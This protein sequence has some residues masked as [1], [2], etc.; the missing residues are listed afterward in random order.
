MKSQ[1]PKPVQNQNCDIVIYDG[2]CKF[3]TKQV[4][5]LHRLDGKN[6]LAFLSLHDAQVSVLLP[7]VTYEE[8]MEQMYLVTS[9]GRVFAGAAAFRYLTR[10]L[11]KLWLAAPIMHIPFSLPLWQWAYRQVA[12][13]RYKMG[14]VADPCEDGSC[15]LHFEDQVNSSKTRGPLVGSE[16]VSEGRNSA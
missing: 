2:R 5:R 6:R 3:C 12:K 1:L 4:Q 15:S 10:R 13:R 8:L 16:S 14:Q 11:P 7:D 9:D